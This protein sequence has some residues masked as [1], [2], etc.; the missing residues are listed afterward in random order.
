MDNY[1]R[2]R[3]VGRGA[4]G[5]VYLCK[6]LIDGKAVIIKE[7]PVEGMTKN[8][9]LATMNEVRILALLDHPNIIEYYENFIQ[10]QAMMIVMEFA[11]GGTLHDLIEKQANAEEYMEEAE[12]AHLFAQIIM[13]MKMVH[14]R[15]ILHRD[16]KTQNIFLTKTMD[17]IKIGDFG[18]SKIL[19]SKS[20]AFTVVG[21]PCYISPELC[22]GKAYNQ[23]SDVWALGCILYE[24]CTLKRAF[25]APTLPALVLKIMR[26]KFNP[27]PSHYS[28]SLRD[29]LGSLLAV[30]PIQRPTLGMLMA[31]PW[32]AP[33]LYRIPTSLGALP[34]TARPPRPLSMTKPDDFVI[35]PHIL[36]PLLHKRSTSP[37]SR[38]PKKYVAIYSQMWNAH[39]Q[40][41]GEDQVMSYVVQS[42]SETDDDG[43]EVRQRGDYDLAQ[44]GILQRVEVIQ[45]LALSQSRVLSVTSEGQVLDWRAHK[46]PRH[47]SR[48]PI[49]RMVF[50]EG[51]N[52]RGILFT[53]GKGASGCLG[54][55]DLEDVIRP[56]IVEALL[57]D[58]VL[59]IACLSHKIAIQTSE[60]E[61]FL[62]G[63]DLSLIPQRMK[64]NSDIPLG[65]LALGLGTNLICYGQNNALLL[66]HR[67]SS[68]LPNQYQVR[69]EEMK[70]IKFWGDHLVLLK[71]NGNVSIFHADKEHP[72]RLGGVAIE[73]IDG[74]A[75][76]P[77]TCLLLPQEHK[78]F[79]LALQKSEPRPREGG[80]EFRV[81]KLKL[82]DI[83]KAGPSNVKLFSVSPN[84][85][86][87]W[88]CD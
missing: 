6:R 57:G 45:I 60:R 74:H 10:D 67:G 55:G 87:A 62:W 83:F 86:V 7:I 5:T 43:A 40:L 39:G 44:R 76:S 59:S 66:S 88:L 17:H 1:Q 33:T 72:L 85:S 2:I 24:M 46:D 38:E 48:S 41:S 25:E 64:I 78:D 77:M 75:Q 19:T 36:S 18:I 70:A 51:L 20:K 58:E 54:H 4:F 61:I 42:S 50:L 56:K 47:I 11:A 16:L 34:C 29:F 9:R 30:D 65:D 23:K 73:R 12:I 22:E 8:D 49:N 79:I 71:S 3:V 84:D 82:C 80:D 68:L 14:C 28:T 27:I 26:G 32:L 37:F 35:S 69:G 21:T 63:H 52:D 31:H 53:V 13:P 81:T 15:Q